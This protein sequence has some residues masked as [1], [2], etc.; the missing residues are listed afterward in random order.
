MERAG[1]AVALAQAA[2]VRVSAVYQ[3]R[4]VPAARVA[5]VAAKIGIPAADLRPDLAA[6]FDTTATHAPVTS[7]PSEVSPPTAAAAE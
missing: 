5:V 2:G 3:W 6:M 4:R 1:G 7:P